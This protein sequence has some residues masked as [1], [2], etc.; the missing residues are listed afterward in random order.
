MTAARFTVECV[1]FALDHFCSVRPDM[2]VIGGGGSRNPTLLRLFREI[3]PMPVLINE[4]LGYDSDAKEAVAFAVL[5][6]ECIHGSPNNMPGVTGA[7]HP[8]VLGKITL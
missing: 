7:D 3:L 2:L 8:V 6:S 1:H 5:A 4:D